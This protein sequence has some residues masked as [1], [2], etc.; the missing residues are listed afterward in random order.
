MM[1]I[2]VQTAA[3]FTVELD[4]VDFAGGLKAP[5]G[6]SAGVAQ[7]WAWGAAGKSASLRLGDTALDIPREGKREDGYVWRKAGTLEVKG[8][9]SL[10]ISAEGPVAAVALSTAPGYDPVKAA[11]FTRVLD[12]PGELGDRRHEYVRN[13]DTIYTPAGL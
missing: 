1:L 6:E 3:G 8:G 7:V 2:V 9:E 10:P 11:R 13:T 5:E 12:Q 4:A